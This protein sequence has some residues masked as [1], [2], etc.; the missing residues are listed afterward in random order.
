MSLAYAVMGLLAEGEHYGYQLRR[1]IEA[2]LGPEWRIDFGQLYR[3][4]ATITRKRWVTVRLQPGTR[5]PRRKLYS[6]TKRGR[7]EFERWLA[8]PV[9]TREFGRDELVAKLRFGW[10]QR[11]ATLATIVGERR[12]ALEAERR[13]QQ[14]LCERSHGRD[15]RR[16]LLA[17]ARLNHTDAALGWLRSCAAVLPSRAPG[18][19]AR[20]QQPALVA[21]GSD[22]PVL[23]L[24]LGRVAAEHP[25][26]ALSSIAA[27]SLA[28]LVAL[29]E[30]RAHVAGIHLLD[31]DSGEYNVPFVKH[32]LPE[33][34]MLLIH[35]ARREQG[36]MVAA[37]NPCGI[38]DIGDLARRGVRL[39][40]RQRGAGTRLLLHHRLQQANIEPLAVSGYDREAPTH[41]AVAA[42]IAAGT[43]DVGPGIRAVADAWG[44]EFIPLGREQYDLAIPR[45]VFESP[46]LQ[47]LLAALHD[48]GFRRAASAF[49]GYD[50]S[51]MAQ[52]VAEL[53]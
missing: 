2:E 41:N 32:L 47:P 45:P 26:L 25:D 52:I 11:R 8:R 23:D 33:E 44:L 53:H 48:S 13:T 9:A 27:G 40:N 14:D 17:H 42:A 35:L 18:H 28:G 3:L 38:R 51:M 30:G 31:V 4:L 22:D 19:A 29:R 34:P 21:V 16:W 15:A 5:G 10:Q 36:L 46:H 37:G 12:E 6:L 20:V 1:E 50:V 43:A 7:A 39:I 49:S 24:L